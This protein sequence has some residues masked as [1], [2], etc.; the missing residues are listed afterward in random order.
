[1]GDVTMEGINLRFDKNSN[2][3]DLD[4]AAERTVGRRQ[5]E[6]GAE[7]DIGEF[8]VF[9]KCLKVL[10]RTNRTTLDIVNTLEKNCTGKFQK[11]MEKAKLDVAGGKSLSSA[12]R[13]S[14][15]FSEGF[16]NIF[17]V[18]EISGNLEKA[19]EN[20]I[21]YIGKTMGMRRSLQ[22]A[23]TYPAVMTA[24][25]IIALFA[26]IF[27]V[28]PSF[29]DMVAGITL[30]M[31]D[32]ELNLPSRIFFGLHSF[33]APLGQIFPLFAIVSFVAYMF[34]KGKKQM[35]RL[36]ERGIPKLRRI[37]N[38]MDWG[39][40]LLLAGVAIEAG[41]LLP[42]VLKMLD[43]ENLPEELTK[44]TS[45]GQTVYDDIIFRTNGGEKL[46]DA[47]K[48]YPI[49]HL[50]TNSIAIAEGAGNLEETMRDVAEIYLEGSDY[51]I[52]NI[53]EIINPVITIVIAVFVAFIVGGL[54]S[55][56]SSINTLVTQM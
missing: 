33:F 22:S 47:F 46:S 48:N 39:Q 12:L 6:A 15:F 55:V 9:V 4:G 28:I 2:A 52:K 17:E 50:V 30:G 18:G 7:A 20:Y 11:A 13:N 32:V 21:V 23:M 25:I 36:F 27:Y 1:V 54:L 37:K 51:K 40:Y 38:E 31:S 44:T 24:V 19:L 14:G 5:S 10:L 45:A 42:R 49:P 41:M 3:S 29:K 43:G 56:M 8:V 26:V 34:W 53:T 35:A 16:C